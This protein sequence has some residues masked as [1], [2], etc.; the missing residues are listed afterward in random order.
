M[1]QPPPS[2]PVPSGYPPGQPPLPGRTR[3]SGWWF[4]LGGGLIVAALAAGAAVFV[5]TLWPLI[6]PGVDVPADGQSHVLVLDTDHE[7]MLWRHS[8]VFDPDCSVVDTATGA[9][10]DLRPV[11]SQITKDVGDGAWT[12]AYR[13][14]PGSGTLDVTCAAGNGSVQ[15]ARAP[16]IGT[17]VGGVIATIAVPSLLGLMGLAILIVTGV[18]WATRPPRA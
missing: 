2:Y 8:D 6:E 3:P 1:S 7:L 4:V 11:T 10:V 17:F 14:D 5:W 18:L 15:L 9:E 16:Q 12:A 13:L